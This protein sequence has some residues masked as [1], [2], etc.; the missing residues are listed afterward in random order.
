MYHHLYHISIWCLERN[1]SKEVGVA[2]IGIFS[3]A[4]H[5]LS[6]VAAEVDRWASKD[7]TYADNNALEIIWNVYTFNEVLW[8]KCP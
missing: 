1:K 8:T 3:L 7:D 5:H 4:F 2:G 6:D